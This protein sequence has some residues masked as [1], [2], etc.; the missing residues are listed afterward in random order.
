MARRNYD[1][2]QWFLIPVPE[3]YLA[4]APDHRFGAG[5]VARGKRGAIVFI[6]VFGPW[7]REP[8]PE[9]LASLQPGGELLLELMSDRWLRDGTFKLLALAAEFSRE[10]WPMPEFSMYMGGDNQAWAIKT[11]PDEP[12]SAVDRRPITPAE[13]YALPAW[14]VGG[15]ARVY[16]KLADPG[17]PTRRLADLYREPTGRP[18]H[19]L[20]RPAELQVDFVVS[21][22]SRQV[23]EEVGVTLRSRGWAVAISPPSGDDGNALWVSG[24][25]LFDRFPEL[26]A[27]DEEMQTI[28][29]SMPGVEYDGHGIHTSGE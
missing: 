14:A 17:A 22:G 11:S 4:D 5:L 15:F 19:S 24:T 28:A 21:G 20:E 26:D 23:A 25:Q 7:E 13:A 12:F 18:S 29:L 8:E 3:K 1:E 6:Y 10:R 27:L 2:G 9:R 16:R